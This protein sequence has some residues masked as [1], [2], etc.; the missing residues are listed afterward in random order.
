MARGRWVLGATLATGPRRPRGRRSRVLATALAVALAAASSA[1]GASG[2]V[3]PIRL[4]EGRL[5]SAL[6]ELAVARRVGILFSPD[7]VGSRLSPQVTGRMSVEEALSRLLVDSGLGFRRTGEGAFIIY[8]L[9]TVEAAPVVSEVLVVGQKMQNVDIRRTES[10]IQPYQVLSSRDIAGFRA[11][12]VGQLIRD[13]FTFDAHG[14]TIDPFDNRSQ[15]NIHGLSSD[16]TL[17]LVDGMRMPGIPQTGEVNRTGQPDLNAIPLMAIER[18]EALTATSGGIYGPG[19][20]GGV[21][22]VVL[23]RDYR[24]VE[25]STGLS[26][27]GAGGGLRKR[28]DARM[29]FTPDHGRTDVMLTVS[30]AISDGLAVGERDYDRRSRLLQLKTGAYPYGPATPYSEVVSIQSYY[31]GANL[32]FKPALG[33][34]DLGTATLYLPTGYGDLQASGGLA[35]FAK[36]I[37]PDDA[38]IM[39]NPHDG[40]SLTP[41]FKTTSV[42]AS[43][44]HDFGHGVEGFVDGI[45]LRNNSSR[46][47]P[48]YLQALI[49]AADPVNLF[50]QT[51]L[52]TYPAPMYGNTYLEKLRTYRV[53]AGLIASLGKNWRGEASY[54]WGGVRSVEKQVS[55]GPGTDLIYLMYA[56]LRNYY[57]PNYSGPIPNVFGSWAKLQDDLKQYN[58]SGSEGYIYHQWFQ[59]GSLRLGGPVAHTSAGPIS[60]T[61]TGEWRREAIGA[62]ERFEYVPTNSHYFYWPYIQAVASAHGEVRAPLVSRDA[63][64]WALRGLELQLAGRYDNYMARIPNVQHSFEMQDAD[65]KTL[66]TVAGFRVFPLKHLMARASIAT[67]TLPPPPQDLGPQWNLGSLYE[68]VFDGDPRRGGERP[69]TRAILWAG[70]SPNVRPER[71]RSVSFGLV[72]NPEGGERPRV[73]LDYTRIDKHGELKSIGSWNSIV[74]DESLYPGRV[75]RAP[76]TAEDIAAGYTGGVIT[77]IDASPFNVGRATI[78]TVDLKIDYRRPVGSSALLRFYGATTWTGRF[79]RAVGSGDAGESFIGRKEGPIT[80]RANGGVDLDYGPWT[81]GL[82]GQFYGPYNNYNYLV[83]RPDGGTDIAISRASSQ[84]YLDL[85]TAYR[86][87]RLGDA[88]I[89][90]LEFKF[91]IANLLDEQGPV[92]LHDY[93]PF[94]DPRGRR[95][96]ATITARF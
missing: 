64:L 79:V 49:D 7:T 76:L 45:Y 68:A 50:S 81:V 31:S 17:V 6:Q 32:T 60:L 82:N 29:G 71:A 87:D 12:Q 89:R 25:I 40:K 18:I 55:V 69:T 84:F 20:T 47:E 36:A 26:V 74:Q 43:V 2:P 57:Y 63:K 56:P 30:R 39:A 33:G 77:E 41:D 3:A 10:D 15:F 91:G 92:T 46:N 86:L 95:F 62:A 34:Q 72:L 80:W 67:G 22:N 75:K 44:R 9:E 28:L 11:D 5:A 51:V 78:E 19:A 66:A 85:S 23:K 70:G 88:A 53:T 59:A 35:W 38:R 90:S 61:M 4:K 8:R 13:R 21:I 14:A 83:P 94:G 48:G 37:D 65:R 54:S 1:H 73:S 93:S 16:E 96:D 27:T 58:A 24:G 42:I 52:V